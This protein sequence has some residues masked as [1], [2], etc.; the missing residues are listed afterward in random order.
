MKKSIVGICL[1]LSFGVQAQRMQL[2]TTLRP[3]MTQ[4]PRWVIKFSPLHLFDPDN[5]VQFGLERILS[6]RQSV[7][8]EFGFGLGTFNVWQGSGSG[9][10]THWEHWRGR[11]EWRFYTNRYRSNRNVGINVRSPAPLGNYLAVE[12]FY[13]Q[14]N[15]VENY[16]VGRECTGG[17]C[18]FFELRESPVTKYVGGSHFKLGRQFAFGIDNNRLMMDLYMGL[19][20]RIRSVERP[21]I[22]AEDQAFRSGGFLVFDPFYQGASVIPSLTAGLKLGYIL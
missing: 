21:P 3:V 22:A 20:L 8:G 1:L 12:L 17:P 4:P 5:T 2:D 15:A 18:A 10:Y 13:K 19:G 11:A 9:R 6:P 14:V 16:T 7:Q